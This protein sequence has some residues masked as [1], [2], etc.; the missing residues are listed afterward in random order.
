LI[1]ELAADLKAQ[2][3]SLL[4]LLNQLKEKFGEISTG[5]VSIRVQALSAIGKIMQHVRNQPPT[6]FDGPL[7]MI[8]LAKSESLRTDAVIV[9]NG[10]VRMI[11]RPSG[12][13]PKLKCYLQYNGSQ[14]DLA[15]LKDFAAIYLSAAQ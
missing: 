4:D 2:G 11:F 5:Q 7:N 14:S 6:N 9:E 1:A 13:E 12:T 10:K 8:D 15:R 3:K